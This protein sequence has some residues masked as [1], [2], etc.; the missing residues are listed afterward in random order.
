MLIRLPILK[1]YVIELKGCM[2]GGNQPR[3]PIIQSSFNL[4]GCSGN[5][6]L[7]I[8][9]ATEELEAVTISFVQHEQILATIG[10]MNLS[11]TLKFS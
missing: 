1:I 3:P 5:L 9:G 8:A 7:L 2:I 11:E 6:P 10:V 4:L